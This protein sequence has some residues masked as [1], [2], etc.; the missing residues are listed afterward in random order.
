MRIFSFVSQKTIIY[1]TLR[2]LWLAKK[3]K[4]PSYEAGIFKV[5]NSE[6]LEENTDVA[7]TCCDAE[8]RAD[9]AVNM[10]V[11]EVR[12]LRSRLNCSDKDLSWSFISST[13]NFHL[14]FWLFFDLSSVV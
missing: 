14:S 12:T 11:T 9:V 3:E 13:F 6:I 7:I 5:Y 4:P 10:N 1:A 2:K 8:R